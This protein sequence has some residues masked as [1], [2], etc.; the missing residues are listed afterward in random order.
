MT[1]TNCVLNNITKTRLEKRHGL[2]R[3]AKCREQLF[4]GDEIVTVPRRN[5]RGY[6]NRRYHKE[7][8]E[9]LHI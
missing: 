8:F 6:H 5:K 7:C 3:C 2:L 9:R 1:V 4:I